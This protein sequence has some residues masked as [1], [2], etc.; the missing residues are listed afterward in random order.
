MF[1]VSFTARQRKN[2]LFYCL[3]YL[4]T[5]E[6]DFPNEQD[7]VSAYADFVEG[8]AEKYMLDVYM[9]EDKLNENHTPRTGS[10][11][12]LGCSDFELDIFRRFY[13][14]RT[15]RSL[16]HYFPQAN[17][18]LHLCNITDENIN[19]FGNLTMI[20]SEANSMGANWE[21]HIK[22]DRYLTMTRKVTPVSVASLKFMIMLQKCRD[23]VNVGRK[24]GDEWNYQDIREHQEKM[25]NIMF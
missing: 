20:G 15:R 6:N 19:C 25:L 11:D 18:E 21:P 7:R 4:F 24:L 8:L 1:E 16:E 12:E 9:D 10:F 23:N 17:V 3:L 22:I 14:S 13:F 5:T 2:Y